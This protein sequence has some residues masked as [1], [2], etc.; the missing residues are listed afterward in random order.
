MSVF[1]QQAAQA[2]EVPPSNQEEGEH[3]YDNN[4]GV[5]NYALPTNT[6]SHLDPIPLVVL[7]LD[8]KL[9]ESYTPCKIS[10]RAGDGLCFLSKNEDRRLAEELLD[11]LHVVGGGF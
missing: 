8:F 1:L 10:I 9:D 2:W 3:C 7:Y 5:T 4:Q 6:T 11:L